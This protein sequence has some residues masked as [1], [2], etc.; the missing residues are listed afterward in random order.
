MRDFGLQS[1][2]TLSASETEEGCI[3]S[4]CR[5]GLF[6]S[7]FVSSHLITSLKCSAL[8]LACQTVSKEFWLQHICNFL[9]SVADGKQ[10]CTLTEG[11]IGGGQKVR[12]AFPARWYESNPIQHLLQQFVSYFTYQKVLCAI[13]LKYLLCIH[14]SQFPL[15]LF[16]VEAEQLDFFFHNSPFCVPGEFLSMLA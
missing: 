16:S 3:C 1:L 2:N 13:V 6:T 4:P 11:M 14:Y 15:S 9:H 8:E 12:S 10:S 7:S 5:L